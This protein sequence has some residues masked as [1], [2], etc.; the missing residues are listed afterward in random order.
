MASNVEI[1]PMENDIEDSFDAS[2]SNCLDRLD[3]PT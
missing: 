3:L 2:E 1:E